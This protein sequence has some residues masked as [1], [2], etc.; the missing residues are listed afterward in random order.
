MGELL[1]TDEFI[2]RVDFSK[3]VDAETD[4]NL[5]PVLPVDVGRI[6]MLGFMNE[7]ALAKTIDTG[8]L[9]MWSRTR[10]G[11]WTKGEQSGNVAL[12]QR[13]IL[14]C[15][16]DTI[17]AEV[18]MNGSPMCHTGAQTCFDGGYVIELGVTDEFR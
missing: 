8:M 9:T 13:L 3:L 16:D 17:L 15:D 12:V 2:S 18:K 6:M 14:D 4:T 10:K 7:E 11:L 1:S 5:V